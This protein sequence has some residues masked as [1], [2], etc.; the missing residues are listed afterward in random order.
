MITLP[1]GAMID[2]EVGADGPTGRTSLGLD[3]NRLRARLEG[4]VLPALLALG[5]G[6]EE[7]DRYFDVSKEWD[8]EHG[9][10][11]SPCRLDFSTLQMAGLDP[12]AEL[13]S[14]IPIWP[15]WPL[16]T[17]GDATEIGSLA[18]WLDALKSIAE[19]PARWTLPLRKS[20]FR[21]Q[22]PETVWN[23][24]DHWFGSAGPSPQFLDNDSTLSLHDFGITARF[25]FDFKHPPTIKRSGFLT[26]LI[27][28]VSEAKD[29]A[30]SLSERSTHA[31]WCAVVPI[32]SIVRIELHHRNDHKVRKMRW[33]TDGDA[34]LYARRGYGYFK[35]VDIDVTFHDGWRL[36][37][38]SF[39][40]REGQSEPDHPL[41][42]V[43]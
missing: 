17:V 35:G 41:R 30:S 26:S 43:G 36:N 33:D 5:Y 34:D 15:L 6:M 4:E 37:Q 19:S 10:F 2:I 28:G 31:E 21:P 24:P 42:D 16:R 22:G 25:G 13:V 23:P 7:I 39:S 3:L 14:P 9:P 27:P 8:P 40:T 18:P 12:P 38:F 32:E 1:N 29:L 11:A 20:R